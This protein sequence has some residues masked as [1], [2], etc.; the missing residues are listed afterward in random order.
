VLVASSNFLVPNG[1]FIVEL[2]AFL[3]VVFLL[4]RYV[5]PPL[6]RI[7]EERQATIRQALADAEE[8][9][10]RAAEA[11]EEYK[12][13]VGEARTQAR[14]VVEEANKMAEQARAERRQQAEAEYE[15]IVSSA[16]AEVEAQT[17]RAQE[18]LRQQAADLAIA[19]AE[20]VLGEGIDRNAQAG[21]IDRTIN[22][23]GAAHAGAGAGAAGEN[24]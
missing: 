12:R 10:R 22:E 20:K 2:V 21:L 8:A 1:T 17:R 18:E 4:A 11:E 13:I 24:A 3:I 6:N 23:F 15:R 9:K 14:A 16:G 19:V 7:M 5:L